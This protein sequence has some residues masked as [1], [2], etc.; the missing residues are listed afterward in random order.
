MLPG[1]AR[2]GALFIVCCDGVHDNLSEVQLGSLVTA[3][4]KGNEKPEVAAEKIVKKAIGNASLPGGKPDDVT[5]VVA[6]V[7][8][9]KTK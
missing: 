5:A 7:F 3:A 6:Y 2:A 9:E 8:E 4:Y 1:D